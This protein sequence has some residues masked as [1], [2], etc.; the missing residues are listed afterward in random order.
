[1]VSKWEDIIFQCAT[2]IE[3]KFLRNLTP[4]AVD[5]PNGRS[6]RVL[7]QL[8]LRAPPGR[9]GGLQPRVL[10]HRLRH[11]GPGVHGA[12]PVQKKADQR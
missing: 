8:P 2:H 6:G 1:M 11:T 9:A 10:Q 4:F 3:V 7:L 12:G 5:L